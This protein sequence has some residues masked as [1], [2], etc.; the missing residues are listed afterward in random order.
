MG[1]SALLNALVIGQSQ[2]NGIEFL[3]LDGSL[4]RGLG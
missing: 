2:C 3:E 4:R 1:W